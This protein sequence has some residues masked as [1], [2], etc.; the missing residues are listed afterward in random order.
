MIFSEADVFAILK[1]S[2][3]KG[4]ITHAEIVL[5][6]DCQVNEND[7]LNSTI[8]NLSL[9]GSKSIEYAI[10]CIEDE[11]SDHADKAIEKNVILG[12]IGLNVIEYVLSMKEAAY[13][14]NSV[15]EKFDH[16]TEFEIWGM[17]LDDIYF[18][19]ARGAVDE[20]EQKLIST[21]DEHLGIAD[22]FLSFTNIKF[23]GLQA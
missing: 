17:Y 3:Q 1:F 9:S 4:L 13:L 7:H 18:G 22:K 15:L 20:L 23:S 14:V 21:F 16:K 2:L 6:A 8:L 5:W 12:L 19:I 11:R 10:N